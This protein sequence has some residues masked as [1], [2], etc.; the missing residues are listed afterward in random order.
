MPRG[1]FELYGLAV[2]LSLQDVR[3]AA[4]RLDGHVARTPCRRSDRLTQ[5]LG[6]EVFLKLENFQLTGSFKE[7]G[8]ANKLSASAQEAAAHGVVT[9]SAGN[10]GQGLARHAARMGIDAIVVMPRSTPLVK[11]SATGRWGAHV[12]LHGADYAEAYSEA[13]LI[14]E[15]EQRLFVHPFD[16][17]D[18]M[19]GQGTV[20]LEI[21]EQVPDV[22]NMVVSVGGGGLAA[23][24]AAVI[25]EL[26]PDIH[27]FGVQSKAMPSM[28][29]ALGAGHP[30]TIP[31]S[32]TVA[33]G[34]AVRQ[35]GERTF[36]ALRGSFAELSVVDDDEISEAIV[37]LLEAEKVLAEGAGAAP[38]AALLR[39]RSCLPGKTVLVICGGNI[40]AN[41][42][43]RVIERG[44]LKNGRL[45]RLRIGLAD[46]P[47][48][49]ASLLAIIGREGGNILQVHHDR[50][51]ARAAMG[52][53]VVDL[54]LETRGAEHAGRLKEML[55]TEHYELH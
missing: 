36:D 53:A 55:Q 29:A 15:R 4:A 2:G 9:A 19:A 45:Q 35:V 6:T 48:S 5:L 51:S 26:R 20:A 25:R 50:T 39:R 54:V 1:R 49:L 47:G 22:Q 18:I 44:L 14:A 23:G 43:S 12:V 34:I 42:L 32:R 31:F 33:D 13:C 11:V 28:Q 46:V 21:L 16:D 30:V 3:D 27:L 7:R 17:P 10:H 8:A 37:V 38:L 40:D 41:V 52:D 24:V